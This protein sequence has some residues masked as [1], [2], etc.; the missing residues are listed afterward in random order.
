MRKDP[1]VSADH[2][3]WCIVLQ[4]FR[5]EA[6]YVLNYVFF[7]KIFIICDAG[8]EYFPT[9]LKGPILIDYDTEFIKV[10]SR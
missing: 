1:I 10:R 4:R 6:H 3:K 5:G 2:I 9:R 8:I 7:K